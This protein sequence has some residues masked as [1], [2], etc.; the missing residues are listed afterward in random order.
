M[1][2]AGPRLKLLAIVVALMFVALATRLWFLQ[3]LAVEE[4]RQLAKGQSIRFVPIEALR[5]NILDVNGDLIVGNR[6]SLQVR[7]D[8]EKL[9]GDVEAVLQNLA[10]VLDVPVQRLVDRLETNRY[11][12]RQ[13]VPVADF[14]SN[15][16]AFYIEE[17]PEL[18][19]PEVVQVET[20]GV[21]DYPHERMAAHVLGHIGLIEEPEYQQLKGAGY[22][23][24]DTLGKAGLEKVYE[25]W[26]RGV[27]GVERYIVNADG[28]V[29]RELDGDPAADGHDLV[30]AMDLKIQQIAEEELRDGLA[31]ARSV[32][33]EDTNKYL[34]ANGGAVVVMN[35]NT[36]GVVAMASWPDYD[37]RWYVRGPTP[38]QQRYLFRS[39]PLISPSSNRATQFELTPGSTLKPFVTLSALR[40]GI[41]SLSRSYHCP[42]Q[43]T[44]PGDTSG[45]IF[46]NSYPADFGYLSI[47]SALKV[48]CDTIFYDWGFDFYD[49]WTQDQLGPQPFQKDLRGFGF[50][51]PTKVDLPAESEGLLYGA[52][53]APSHPELFYAGQ[54]QPGGDILISIG[55]SYVTTTPLQLATA[56][57]AIANDGRMCRPHLAERIVAPDGETVSDVGGHCRSLGYAKGWVQY[58]RSALQ[59]VTSEE[60]GTAYRA[61]QGFPLAQVPVAGKTGTAE[62]S[63]GFQDTS[64]FA[65]MVPADDPQYVV[66]VM[67]E[68]GGFGSQTAA[69]ITRR[70]IE[71]IYGI[72]PSTGALPVGGTD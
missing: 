57:S 3:V 5:G 20:T 52:S 37:P 18:F 64:W 15:E 48:S 12:R 30:L 7:V 38:E 43:Y 51:R 33:D 22:G 25:P 49:R 28:E 55:S 60:G 59:R 63:G 46:H 71:R 58:I 16:T 13:P 44:A 11:L 32:F 65:A 21:R 14:V 40:R 27:R 4:N 26:L 69:P 19:P 17:H 39:K 41:A 35:P 24:N 1:E 34:A 47:S 50:D 70:I 54:W 36:G 53:D 9:G 62:R 29:I 68:Q 61:F 66:V 67:A 2:K 10:E 45:A 23:V 6:M 31:Q 42:A 72:E 56:Y 8:R